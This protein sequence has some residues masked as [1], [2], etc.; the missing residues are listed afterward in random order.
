MTDIVFAVPVFDQLP[1]SELRMLRSIADVAEEMCA[2]LAGLFGDEWQQ[3]DVRIADIQ[4]EL[5]PLLAEYRQHYP[6][7]SSDDL[8]PRPT[9]D[10]FDADAR[11]IAGITPDDPDN[12]PLIAFL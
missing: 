6:A 4:D 7:R 11:V 2:N 8:A 9:R 1:A 3:A 12:F 5:V 10:P